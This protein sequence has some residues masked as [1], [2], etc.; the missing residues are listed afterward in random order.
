M[1]DKGKDNLTEEQK[2][3]L[4]IT[5]QSYFK[6]LSLQQAEEIKKQDKQ[7]FKF[8]S[9]QPVPALDEE[10]KEDGPIENDTPYDQIKKE[11]YKLPATF[12]WCN[13]N[14][15]DPKELNELYT[16]LSENYVEDD[17]ALFRFD[18][19]SDF[20]KWALQP[21]GWKPQW[22]LGV[23]VK[24]NNKLVAFISG[25]PTNLRIHK[26][27]QLLVEI[28]FLCVH[29][30]LRSK[31]LAPVLIKEVTRRI[32][33]EGIFQALYTA[34]VH[35][36]KPISVCRYYHRSLN[37]KKLVEVG[38]SRLK[39]NKSMAQTIKYYRLPEKP[40]IPGFREMKKEDI[41]AVQKLLNTYLDKFDVA[42]V[43]SREDIEHWL[44]PLDEVVYSYVVE[45]DNEITEFISFYNL[46]STI[47]D[48]PKYKEIKAAYLFYYCQEG[49]GSKYS[50]TR[51]L[52]NDALIMAKANKFDVFNCLNLM[53][54]DDVLDDLKFGKGDGLLNYYLYNYRCVEVKPK[55]LGVVLLY[56]E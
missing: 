24:S 8:W 35:L 47:I 11:E 1:S 10:V 7:D 44:I 9:T 56:S 32:H 49:M 25:I 30:K 50:A 3:A 48:N 18:Y 40:L 51:A 39:K 45:K 31:R 33:L 36:P 4:K 53:D 12:T 37:P 23:R 14:V 20:L 28:N 22:L 55:K 54:N 19:S 41:D 43:F 2:Q 21:P 42:P 34:G 15:D 46:P 27:Q 52:I 29:K 26:H 13:V 6:Q 17:D 5:L 38:F 16:L